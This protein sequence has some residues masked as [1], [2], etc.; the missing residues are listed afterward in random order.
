[1]TFFSFIVF[2]SVNKE[3]WS[4]FRATAGPPSKAYSKKSSTKQ[5]KNNQIKNITRKHLKHIVLITES[6]AKWQHFAR[7]RW[8]WRNDSTMFNKTE[9]KCN[10]L[11]ACSA[12]EKEKY[13]PDVRLFYLSLG[14]LQTLT[15]GNTLLSW[16]F[17]SCR[18][19]V[20]LTLEAVCSI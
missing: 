5:K 12:F 19:M 1:M 7:G 18:W 11:L 16:N 6:M 13:L 15:F 4:A 2:V 8:S 9:V 14:E 20:S 17:S 10:N 3:E